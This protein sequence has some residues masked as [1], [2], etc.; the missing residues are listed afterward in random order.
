[1]LVDARRGPLPDDWRL[2]ERL[3]G[4][5]VPFQLVLTKADAVVRGR[6]GG[7]GSGG[8]GGGGGGGSEEEDRAAGEHLVLRARTMQLMDELGQWVDVT[9]THLPL[10]HAVSAKTGGGI[11]ELQYAVAA[12]LG[13]IDS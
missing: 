5:H 2:M 12:A 13:M 7:S 8:G 1:M 11:L 4:A 9:P 6:Q 3:S 10:V